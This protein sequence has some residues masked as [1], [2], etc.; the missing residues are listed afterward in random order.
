MCRLLGHDRFEVRAG[1][2]DKLEW[3]I[4][5]RKRLTAFGIL[6]GSNVKRL[7]QICQDF[8]AGI[9]NAAEGPDFPHA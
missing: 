4:A 3:L 5:F 7:S 6:S 9:A 2:E 1:L 8:V